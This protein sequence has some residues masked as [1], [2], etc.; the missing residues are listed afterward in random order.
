L[1][2]RHVPDAVERA[3]QFGEDRG[4]AHQQHDD[5]DHAGDQASLRLARAAHQPLHGDR[6]LA[7]DQPGELR[8]DLALHR[9]APEQSARDRDDDHQQGR[10][11]EHV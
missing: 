4:G 1:S 7:A 6:A 8:D 10:Q 9:L 11:R 5:A 2:F 3:L